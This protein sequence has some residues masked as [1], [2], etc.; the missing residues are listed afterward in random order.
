MKTIRV[1]FEDGSQ[2]TT[3]INGTYDEIRQYYIGRVFNLGHGEE[4]YITTGKTVEFL[5]E[6]STI[7]LTPLHPTTKNTIDRLDW[8]T[9]SYRQ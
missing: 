1:T 6:K 3:S 7:M 2:L 5:E 8:P 4:D 9:L